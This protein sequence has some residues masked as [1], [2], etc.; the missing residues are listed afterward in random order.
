M[1]W[2]AAEQR[3]G[4]PV[5]AGGARR[6]GRAKKLQML[7]P[8]WNVSGHTSQRCNVCMNSNDKKSSDSAPSALMLDSQLAGKPYGQHMGLAV[9]VGFGHK[10]DL[11]V[12]FVGD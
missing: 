6:G 10:A 9:V 1:V 12:A 11:V 2:L 7:A 5:S 8:F 4:E 3:T